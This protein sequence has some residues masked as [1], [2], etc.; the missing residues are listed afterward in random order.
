MWR[1]I[2]IRVVCVLVLGTSGCSGDGSKTPPSEPPAASTPRAASSETDSPVRPPLEALAISALFTA[3]ATSP[4]DRP[5]DL[6][7]VLDA[8]VKAAFQQAPGLLGW[9]P[10]KKGPDGGIVIR[11][12]V[13]YAIEKEDAPDSKPQAYVAVQGEAIR[14]TVDGVRERYQEMVRSEGAL[15]DGVA[16]EKA[17]ESLLP[18]ALAELRQK[19]EGRI[20]VPYFSDERLI[21]VIEQERRVYPREQ[22]IAEIVER[23]LTGAVPALIASLAAAEEDRAP[24]AE[25]SALAAL[26]DRRAIRAPS[27]LTS[28][29][30]PDLVVA[31]VQAMAGIGGPE[32]Q[33]Y[34]QSIADGHSMLEVRDLARRNLR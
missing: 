8:P 33:R 28:R 19:L 34:L 26:R 20:R 27:R 10:G 25:V 4:G 2:V 31:V 1:E 7:D 30:D 3:D 9:A 23:K 11:V 5:V 22:V 24:M 18:V 14:K 16:P 6:T 29:N 12:A 17:F 15:E 32:A 13:Y 21:S